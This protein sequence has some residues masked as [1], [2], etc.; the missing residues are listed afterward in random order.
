MIW[1]VGVLLPFL[2]MVL[3]LGLSWIITC[4]IVWLAFMCF[5]LTFDWLIA[6]GIWLVAMLLKNIFGK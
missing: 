1:I 6:T 4:G 2:L 5:G 3:S